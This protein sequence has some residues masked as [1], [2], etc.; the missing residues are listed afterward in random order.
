MGNLEVLQGLVGLL[1]DV[2]HGRGEPEQIE[3]LAGWALDRG[4]P[5]SGRPS[6]RGPPRPAR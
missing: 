2:H 4:P 3:P 6:C 5:G 1:P